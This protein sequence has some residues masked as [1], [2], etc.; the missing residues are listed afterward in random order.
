MI[1]KIR[2][3]DD[4]KTFFEQLLEESLNFH[5]DTPF[6]DYINMETGKDTYTISEAAIRNE[7]LD[8]CFKVC[9]KNKVD[10]YDLTQ[11]IFLTGTG[12]NKFF[13]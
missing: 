11:N 4:V 8:K 5:P 7:L 3:I 6:E 12:L 13:N 9:R 2:T 10:I 1:K